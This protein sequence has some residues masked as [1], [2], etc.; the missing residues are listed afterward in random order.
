MNELRFEGA[1]KYAVDVQTDSLWIHKGMGT[2]WL[3]VQL[4]VTAPRAGPA[5][6]SCCW[7]PTCSPRAATGPGPSWARSGC[8]RRS[9]T[10]RSSG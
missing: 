5:A 4:A 1:G 8:Q 3:E 9:A 6:G 10:A 2:H 7:R